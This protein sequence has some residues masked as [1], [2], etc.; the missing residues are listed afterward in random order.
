MRLSLR[1]SILFIFISML[2]SCAYLPHVGFQDRESAY[3]KARSIPP[4]R[5][6]PGHSAT[7]MRSYYPVSSQSYPNS[8]ERVSVV[9]P[10]L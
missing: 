4:M 2:M 10:G 9:P 6:P 1:F 8:K 5:I 7:G 3:L